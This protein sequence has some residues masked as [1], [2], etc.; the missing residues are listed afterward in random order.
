MRLLRYAL[1]GSCA[2]LLQVCLLTIFIELAGMNA[3]LAS[4]V[5]L[6]IAVMVNYSLQHRLT[7]RSKSKHVIAAPR[8]VALA[9]CTL[10]ANAVLFNSLLTVLPYLAAQITTLGAIFPIN[11]YLN[12]TLTFRI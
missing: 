11:Y 2:A 6:A 9:L 4:T 5:A 7:F 1:V 10:A 8:F 12:R 3:L